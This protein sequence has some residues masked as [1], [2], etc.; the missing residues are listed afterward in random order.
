M[1]N[2]KKEQTKE[3]ATVDKKKTDQI[4][5]PYKTN[6][7]AV[8]Y[9]LYSLTNPSPERLMEN[10]PIPKYMIASM[11]YSIV[12]ERA[13]DLSRNTEKEPLSGVARQATLQCLRGVGM[14][15]AMLAGNLIMGGL[16]QEGETNTPKWSR[17]VG[18]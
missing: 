1:D 13:A 17:D 2:E 12:R 14:Q 11:V 4:T 7:E 18:A 9:T 5:I 6:R 16:S 10:A 15:A 3:L 8:L